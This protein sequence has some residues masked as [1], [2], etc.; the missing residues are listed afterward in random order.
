MD[1]LR[2]VI[3]ITPSFEPHGSN[4]DPNRL[5]GIHRLDDNYAR[6][7][8]LSGGLPLI[9]P[10]TREI[11]VVT[12]YLQAVDGLIFSGGGD[13]NPILYGE[14]PIPQLQTVDPSRDEFELG[15]CKEALNHNIPILAICRGV[16]LLNVAAGGKLVQDISHCVPKALQHRQQAPIWHGSHVIEITPDSLLA[17]LMKTTQAQVNSSHHQAV[18]DVAPGFRVTARTSDGVIEAIESLHHDFVIGVQFHPEGMYESYDYAA[19]LFLGFVEACQTV[20]KL[21]VEG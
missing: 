5:H 15:L 9:L 6:A 8:R 20:K 14:D 7:V 11:Q 16:Q 1:K 21:R 2:P 3:G 17:Q 12:D 10:T 4:S 18:G 19:A 13:V